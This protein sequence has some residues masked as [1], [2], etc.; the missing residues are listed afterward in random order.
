[1][2]QSEALFASAARTATVTSR[3]ISNPGF[4]FLDVVL[5]VTAAGTGSVTVTIN[6]KDPA[7]AKYFLLLAGAAVTTI[8]TNQ[9]QVGPYVT[10]A[11]NVKAVRG[12][13]DI[14]QV[15]L[16]ANNANSLTSSVGIVLS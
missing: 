12:L 13:P 5:D 14:L 15:V 11:A 16:T 6:G 1:M 3:D 9:Y 2:P 4:K 8:S 7:S 10:G